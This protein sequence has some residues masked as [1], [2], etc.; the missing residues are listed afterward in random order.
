[1]M[2]YAPPS[3]YLNLMKGLWVNK[4]SFV[5]LKYNSLS[6]KIKLTKQITKFDKSKLY[7]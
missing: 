4:K 7:K 2:F 3:E 1:M 5:S 6:F